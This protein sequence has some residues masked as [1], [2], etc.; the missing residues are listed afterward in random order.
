MLKNWFKIYV[1]NSK[2]N[3]VYFLLTL[4]CLAI[5]ITAVLLSTLYFKEEY[6]FDQW[7]EN[8]ETIYFVENKGEKMSMT[9]HPYALG[10]RLKE[11]YSFVE[12]YLLYDYYQ[13]FDVEYKNKSFAFD[14][15]LKTNETFFDFFPYEMVYGG[16]KQVF[17][18]PNQLVLEEQ[19]AIELFGKGINPMG[20]A[21]KIDNKIFTIVGV[22]R[23]GHKRSSFMPEAVANTYQ[24]L[25]E[26]E[27]TAWDRASAAYLVKTSK[28]AE[29]AK[30]IDALYL[31]YYFEPWA[32]RSNITLEALLE[33]LDG[34]L[35][36]NAYLHQ[37][38]EIHFQKNRP[39]SGI[40]PEPIANVKMLYIIVGLSW[41][42]LLL[43][44]FNYVNLS[45]SQALFRAKEVGIRKVLGG[46]NRDIVK[47]SLFETS[48]TICIAFLVSVFLYY[49]ILPFTNLF[50]QTNIVVR[51]QD[52]ALLFVV[53]YGLLILFAGLIPAFYISKY[54]VLKVLKGDFHRSRSGNMIKNTF[55]IIQFAS[56]CWF[57]SGT[58]I[59]YQQANFMM[60]KD[61][62]FKGDQIISFP[63]AVEDDGEEKYQKYQTFK[64][65]AMRIKG[66][67]QIAVAGVEYGNRG[68]GSTI[69]FFPYKDQNIMAMRIGA[70][71]DY[72][73]MMG[74]QLK[75][76]RLLDLK[77]ATDS[78]ENVMI[79]ESLLSVL[80]ETSIEA[81]KLPNFQIV[82][83]IR[84]FHTGGFENK[85]LPMMFSLFSGESSQ[86][87]S[88]K[89]KVD[90]Q[91]VETLIPALEQLWTKF[92]KE[93]KLPF[94]YQFVDQ[95]FAQTF[96]KIQQQKQVLL[97]LGNIVVFIALFG[98]FAVSS[99]NIGTKLR[100]IAIRKVLGAEPS[101]LMRKLSYQYLIY[102]LIGFGLSIFP[103]YY[104]LN[105]WLEDYAYRIEIGYEV[106]VV[107]FVLMGLLTLAIVVSRAYKATKVNVLEYIKYE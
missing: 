67:E 20:E 69:T 84:N 50:L 89:M 102:C 61:L 33:Q 31:K 3:K 27:L 85:V 39:I 81:V 88:V 42:I 55:L 99:F 83:L 18:A 72:F 1:Y 5:G 6:S 24:F 60:T 30:A 32:A 93:A 22:Y 105:K 86:F 101:E 14:K 10:I 59:V 16:S 98:L 46:M 73:D 52:F 48:I 106:Y 26:E 44:L 41:L 107:C 71:A 7:N 35:I 95:Q 68:G 13:A 2:K 65:E 37:L 62:G 49:S 28:P 96:D 56:A 9:G 8:K 38:P 43:S 63:F 103:S 92:N 21:L 51:I 82:G 45:L 76:G 15:I 100:E 66:V 34:M 36:S 19:K 87:F 29:T 53:V 75:E 74:I 91:Q 54:R 97:Y 104:L 78:I 79:N 47:Q 90:V 80:G 57:I 11:E 25:T 40:F 77:L 58:Y 70:E 94:E 23:I 64:E 4:L 17:N 12:D